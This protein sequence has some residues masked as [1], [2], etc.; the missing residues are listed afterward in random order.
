MRV[1]LVH[2]WLTGMRGGERVLERV[3]RLFPQAPIFTLVWNRGSVSAEL[4]A[5]PIRTSFLQG[6]PG[7]A[8]HYR[9]FLPLF[10]RAIESFDLSGFDAVIS[11]SHAV[12]KGARAGPGAFHLSYI[13]TPMRYVWDLEDTYFPPGR[14]PWPLSAYVKRTCARLRDWDRRTAD[15]AHLLLADSAY[16]A[17]RIRRH[18]GRDAEVVTPPVDVDRFTAGTGA[19]ERYLLAGAFAPYKRGDLALAACAR[20]GRPLTVAGSGQE[21]ARLERL[22]PPGSVFLGW[23]AEAGMPGLY[24]SARALLFPGE[25]D[26]GI[27]PVEAMASGTP[28]V[29]YGRGGALETVGR[30]ADAAALAEVAAGGI[31]RVPGGVLFGTQSADCLAAAIACLEATRFDPHELRALAAPFAAEVFDERFRAAFERGLAT[32]RAG[33]A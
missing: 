1:A 19:R 5:H 17:G 33:A 30:G 10:P 29:A 21:R 16:V 9:N 28:V 13:F 18:W 27:M 32:R 6:L 22:A 26:F 11:T 4:E 24:A 2:D 14:F 7:A 12:A 15:R 31:A 25:E 3:A 20:L 23:V 8:R